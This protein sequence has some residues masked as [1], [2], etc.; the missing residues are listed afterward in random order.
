MAGEGR[1]GRAGSI[2]QRDVRPCRVIGSQNKTSP[3]RCVTQLFA[4][5]PLLQPWALRLSPRSLAVAR[6]IHSEWRQRWAVF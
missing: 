4:T 6:E 5:Y 1:C 2:H 3:K